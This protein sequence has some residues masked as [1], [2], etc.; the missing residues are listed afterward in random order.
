LVPLW[1]RARIASPPSASPTVSFSARIGS[2]RRRSKRK[3][4]GAS[5]ILSRFLSSSPATEHAPQAGA[6]RA[7]GVGHLAYKHR[8]CGK[9][10][11]ALVL[12]FYCFVYWAIEI[13]SSITAFACQLRR[14]L[15]FVLGSGALAATR[16]PS[17]YREPLI[18]VSC[19][20]KFPPCATTVC[21]RSVSLRSRNAWLPQREKLSYFLALLL[22][23]GSILNKHSVDCQ[24]CVGGPQR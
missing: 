2:P 3:T 1:N 10:P 4:R 19:R 14:T 12:V 24:S 6:L 16:S 23:T 21:R 22:S 17:P 18:N 11:H 13:R 7:R 9:R 15:G 20:R 5:L 8:A